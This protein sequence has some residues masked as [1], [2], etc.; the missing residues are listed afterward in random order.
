MTN[1]WFSPAKI[2]AELQK[3]EEKAMRT[4]TPEGNMAEEAKAQH[5][6]IVTETGDAVL[7]PD[8]AK[9]SILYKSTKV[10][11]F[12]CKKFSKTLLKVVMWH[13]N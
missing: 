7:P 4:A 11:P 9:V 6:V 13:R 12:T 3:D 1:Q 8:I 10:R 2:Y 5:K